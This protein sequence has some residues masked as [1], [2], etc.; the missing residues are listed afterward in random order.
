MQLK[1]WG[2]WLKW[3]PNEREATCRQA[4]LLPVCWALCEALMVWQ[5]V[6]ASLG[7]LSPPGALACCSYSLSLASFLS[8]A[9]QTLREIRI[10]QRKAQ[11]KV[12]TNVLRVTSAR[13]GRRQ[14]FGLWVRLPEFGSLISCTLAWNPG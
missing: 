4:T 3:L 5:S 2:V 11:R 8:Q 6:S 13:E 14:E 12:G 10:L 9:L 7:I 1:G